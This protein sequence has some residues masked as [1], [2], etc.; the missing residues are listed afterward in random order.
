VGAKKWVIIKIY[1]K[2]RLYLL[3]LKSLVISH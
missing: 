3:C 1:I 2:M